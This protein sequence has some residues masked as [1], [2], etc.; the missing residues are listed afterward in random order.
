MPAYYII[1][2]SV[3]PYSFVCLKEAGGAE[4][5]KKGGQG[6]VMGFSGGEDLVFLE[7]FQMQREGVMDGGRKEGGR[8][9][10]PAGG[11]FLP[12]FFGIV[13]TSPR[14]STNRPCISTNFPWNSANFG[15]SPTLFDDLSQK[16][17]ASA[18]CFEGKNGDAERQF[19]QRAADFFQLSSE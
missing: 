9:I 6:Q 15:E 17:N 14:N 7:F 11:G 12:T 18:F 8:A 2:L 3:N 16:N 13:P 19:Y 10:L 1:H 4:L 5:G